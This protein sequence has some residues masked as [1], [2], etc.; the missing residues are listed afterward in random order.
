MS[1]IRRKVIL[2]L[3][4]VW[5]FQADMFLCVYNNHLIHILIFHGL[6]S[7]HSVQRWPVPMI[8]S[9]SCKILICFHCN[10][11]TKMRNWRRT[12][13]SMD[14]FHQS[15]LPSHAQKNILSGFIRM[16]LFNIYISWLLTKQIFDKKLLRECRHVHSVS[17]HCF[18][19][20]YIPWIYIFTSKFYWLKD[21]KDS[22][23]I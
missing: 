17:K 18:L 4:L 8:S 22:L 19:K 7:H 23:S 16:V 9:V 2:C 12:L 10:L 5:S 21:N 11:K 13:T 6:F 20:F 14:W 15:H 3:F 1:I